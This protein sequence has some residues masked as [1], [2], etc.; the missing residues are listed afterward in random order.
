VIVATVLTA[1]ALGPVGV[2]LLGATLGA[3]AGAVTTIAHNLIDGKKWSDGVAKAMIVGA[4]GGAFGGVGGVIFKGVGSVVLKIGLEA[5]LDVV[6]GIVGEVTGSLAVG[7]AIDWTNVVVGA[8]IGAGVGAGL[9]IA[10]ALKG[11]FRPKLGAGAPTPSVRPSI[12][13]PPP[14][15]G[16]IGSALE[17]AKILAPRAPPVA[18]PHVGL[19]EGAGGRPTAEGPGARPGVEAPSKIAAPESGGPPRGTPGEAPT[20]PR[21]AH[22]DVPEVEPGVVAKSSAD[23]HEVKVL[24]DGRVVTCTTCGE[25]RAKYGNELADNPSLKRELDSIEGIA[26]P[27][28]KASR[29]ADLQKKLEAARAGAGAPDAAAKGA[30][31]AAPEPGQPPAPAA[32]KPPKPASE[33]GAP[34]E[35]GSVDMKKHVGA[36]TEPP[37]V[38]DAADFSKVK[39]KPEQDAL[40]ILRDA[41]GT[42]LK[43]GKTSGSGAKNRFSVYKRAGKLEGRAL[44]LEVHPLKPSA[45]NAEYHEAALRAKME[46]DG[47]ALPWDNTRGRLGRPGFGTPGEGV[48]T[49]PV[50]TGEMTSL[51]AKH[52]GNLREVGKELGVHR[53]TADLWAKALGLLPKT[54]K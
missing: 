15:R 37:Q 23:G 5:G 30:A 26:D 25:V 35:R 21:T 40:Y 38:L 12:E 9:G 8:L 7:E 47:H 16:R 49:P 32:S 18:K 41:D 14:P 39:L 29:T 17:R 24:K 22:P 4:I 13:A 27:N 10:G 31:P 11:K 2:V 3:L 36:D 19:P 42:I 1:G 45:H 20:A 44:Q 34:P 54:F 43:V 33:A 53:R 6:G 52:K 51:L 50:T 48:R 28:V 46:S